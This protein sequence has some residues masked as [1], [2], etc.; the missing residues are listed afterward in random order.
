M[1]VNH[2]KKYKKVLLCYLLPE[3]LQVNTKPT[4]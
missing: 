1:I 4:K 3:K 2:K